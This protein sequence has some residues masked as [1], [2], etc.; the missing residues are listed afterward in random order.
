MLYKLDIW[1]LETEYEIL[2]RVLSLSASASDWQDNSI[3][4]KIHYWDYII[5]NKTIE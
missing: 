5:K 4:K 2:R 1:K 3:Q